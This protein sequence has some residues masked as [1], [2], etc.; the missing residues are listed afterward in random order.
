VWDG[1]S[2]VMIDR[3]SFGAPIGAIGRLVERLVLGRYL[4]NLIVERGEY[5][6]VEAE[7]RGSG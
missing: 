2:T 7:P 3:R 5:L 1:G 4:G 6:K